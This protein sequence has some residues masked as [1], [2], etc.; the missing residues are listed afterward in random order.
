[1]AKQPKPSKKSKPKT[2]RRNAAN[3][4]IVLNRAGMRRT[5]PQAM[6]EY[7]SLLRDP[8]HGGLVPAPYFGT[9][10]SYII[11]TANVFNPSITGLSSNVSSIDFVYEFT[12][13]NLGAFYVGGAALNGGTIATTSTGLTNFVS[14][15]QVVKGYRPVA[16]CVKYIPTGPIAG[17]AGNIGMAYTPTK[18]ITSGD[19]LTASSMLTNCAVINSTGAVKHEMNWLP[20]QADMNFNTNTGGQTLA[21][22]ASLLMVGGNMDATS[23][24]T[25]PNITAI[26]NGL[27]EITA[28]WEWEPHAVS[29]G[30]IPAYSEPTSWSIQDV[31]SVIGNVADVIFSN[32][33]SVVSGY[34]YA[35][36]TRGYWR[37]Y[38]MRNV[39]RHLEF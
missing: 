34:N 10:S 27:I 11:R 32:M 3:Q 28:V 1:M 35:A 4:A 9:G 29:A 20:S 16:C 25:S 36:G 19:S 6:R 26:A 30:V 12:P 2:S 17:R 7:I 8:C 5:I 23:S 14:N 37:G 21:G 39:N 18:T 22:N 15:T 31:Y 24:G 33:G 38:G 13:W